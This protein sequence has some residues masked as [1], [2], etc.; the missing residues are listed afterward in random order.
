MRK[1]EVVY[2]YFDIT[3]RCGIYSH[4]L[5]YSMAYM[6][7]IYMRFDVYDTGA[8]EHRKLLTT[9][10]RMDKRESMQTSQKQAIS[11]TLK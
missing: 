1:C 2:E 4:K 6:H 3:E 7:I 10:N 11:K 8:A 5:Q 9:H